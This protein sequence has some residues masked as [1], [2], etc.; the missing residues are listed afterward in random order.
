MEGQR[1]GFSAD[2]PIIDKVKILRLGAMSSEDFII[3][4]LKEREVVVDGHVLKEKVVET[5]ELSIF[6]EAKDNPD[7]NYLIFLDRQICPAA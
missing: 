7:K 2:A 3:P 4:F 5:A 6:K 1:I